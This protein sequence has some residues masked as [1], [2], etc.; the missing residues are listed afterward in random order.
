[1]QTD[2]AFAKVFL[3]VFLAGNGRDEEENQERVFHGFGFVGEP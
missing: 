3:R 2:D 1:M